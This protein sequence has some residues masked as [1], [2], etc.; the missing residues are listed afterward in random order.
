MRNPKNNKSRY[1]PPSVPFRVRVQKDWKHNKQVYLMLIPVVAYFIIFH[2]I[3]M[4]GV[5]IAFKNFSISKGIWGSPW[6]G[7]KHFRSYFNSYYF[8]RL[9][10]NT[11]LLSALNILFG[12]PAPIILALM[13][14]EVRNNKFK[15]T[16]QPVTYLPHFISIVIVCALMRTFL[17]PRG[18]INQLRNHKVKE[19]I[20]NCDTRSGPVG[21]IFRTAIEHWQD[22]ETGIR[23]AIEEMAQLLIQRLQF[24]LKLLAML[25][26]CSALLGL[27]G[28]VIGL[29]NAF[30]TISGNEFAGAKELSH[31]VSSYLVCTAV[32]LLVSLVC[33]IFHGVLSCMLDRQIHEMSKGAAEITF[34]LTHNEPP[35]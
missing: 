22:G 23:Y 7:L 18:L 26:N 2:Y 34:F 8:G 4:A 29:V 25:A 24:G 10:K 3:P 1:Q 32:G 5:Q 9:I 30:L 21:E 13:I 11:T 28:T 20:T 15:R 14:N 27:L 12:F 6:V 31:S 16:V 35:S 17:S 33:Q 19:A